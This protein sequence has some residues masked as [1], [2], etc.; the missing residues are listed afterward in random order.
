M[1]TFKITNKTDK[2]MNLVI[3]EK[4]PSKILIQTKKNELIDKNYKLI[5]KM[6]K[7]RELKGKA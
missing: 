1:I 4:K 3:S 2:I 6:Q 7:K 5:V